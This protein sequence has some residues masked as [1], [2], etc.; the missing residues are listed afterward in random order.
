MEYIIG[1]INYWIYIV[2]ILT[3]FFAMMAKGNLMKK[4]IGMNIFQ[5]SIILFFVSIGA[6]KGATVPV[7]GGH[8]AVHDVIHAVDYINPLPHVLMLT[9]IVVGVATT[10]IAL[11]LLIVLYKKYGTLEE[12]E[13][14]EELKR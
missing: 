6:K 7:L 13:I 10:G 3:G 5:W 9:A 14:I 8:G 2:L 1:K 11:T 12:N 4:L